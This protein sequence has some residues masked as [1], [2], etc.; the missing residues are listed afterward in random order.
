MKIIKESTL[1][2]MAYSRIDAMDRCASLGKEFIIHFDKIY[3]NPTDGS[4][5]HW[6]GEMQAWFDKMDE[7]KLKSTNKKL[8]RAKRNDWFYSYGNTWESFFNENE[9]E[10]STYEEFID[11]L[12]KSKSVFDSINKVVIK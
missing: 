3:K 6:C 10:I 9:T 5:N 8:T 2:E 12:E 7:M 4:L 1:N 11:E